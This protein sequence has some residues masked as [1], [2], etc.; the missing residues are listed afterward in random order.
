MSFVVRWQLPAT[1]ASDE[2]QDDERSEAVEDG[3]TNER[4]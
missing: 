2:L 4:G 3:R 1:V